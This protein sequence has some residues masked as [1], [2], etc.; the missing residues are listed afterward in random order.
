VKRKYRKKRKPKLT[1]LKQLRVVIASPSDVKEEREALD[2]VIDKVNDITAESL[3]LILK[4][5]RWETDSYPGFNVDG[6]QGLIDPIIKIDDC[7]ILICIFW[8][9]FGTPIKEDGKTGA[10]HEFYKAY[11]AWKQNNKPHIMLYF[12]QKAYFPKEPEEL[13]QHLAV[14][15]FKKNIPKEGLHWEYNGIEQFR[16]Y[17][18]DHLTKYLQNKFKTESNTS[19]SQN[20][21][22]SDQET[23]K[24]LENYK[25][26]TEKKV[27]KKRVVDDKFKYEP[28][29]V[30]TELQIIK[31]YK[32]SSNE[33]RNEYDD[34]IGLEMNPKKWNLIIIG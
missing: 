26:L 23:E 24:L 18:Y 11:E 4:A 17:V 33:Q 34:L 15:K 27:S 3:G 19:K 1:T 14:L 8:K 6:P 13:E 29:D 10:E 31:Q 12:S 30:L 7:D 28:K 20:Y 25:N 5:V 2:K 22:I 9:R 16:E 21:T 32:R